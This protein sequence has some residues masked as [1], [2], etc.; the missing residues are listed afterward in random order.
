[1]KNKGITLVAVV[2]TVIILLILAGISISSLT[3][4]GIFEKA[5]EA[6]RK[7]EEE[8]KNQQLEISKYEKVLNENSA[9]KLTEDKLNK[10][11]STEKNVI[12]LDER[13]NMFVVPAGFKIVSDSTTNNAITVE[14]GIVVEDA[15]VNEDDIKTETNGSQF[16][17][18][19]VGEVN[20]SDGTKIDIKL[21]RYTFDEEGKPMAQDDKVI[22]L[23]FQELEKSD[24]GNTVAKSINN[25]KSSVIANGG[26]Y[27][28][29]YEARKSSNGTITEVGTDSV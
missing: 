1:M 2:I 24:R 19:P 5:K 18:I 20:K 26:F 23:Y 21:N 25:F 13:G 22:N 3:K 6:K 4:T 11:L 15:T 7:S 29:R 27:I 17:W 8:S 28:G 10:V 9:E 12:L 14:Q 16:V